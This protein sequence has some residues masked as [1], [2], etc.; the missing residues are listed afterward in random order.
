MAVHFENGQRVVF[1]TENVQQRIDNP[2][3]T[4]LMAFFQLCN[5]DEF[6][7]TLFY[8]EVPAFY[9]WK[10][11]MFQRRKKRSIVPGHPGVKKDQ[12]LGKIYTVHPNDS[13][14]FYLRLL[15]H[16]VRGPTSFRSLKM[17]GGIEY[18]TFHAACLAMGLLLDDAQAM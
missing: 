3:K 7:K 2:P 1:T 14:C 12:V 16:K 13:E 8:N 15:L 6:A 18:P 4:T 11:N 5:Q 9:V 17:V 10:N